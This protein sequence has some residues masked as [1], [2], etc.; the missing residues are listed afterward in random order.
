MFRQTEG[1]VG[2][3]RGAVPRLTEASLSLRL[4][5]VIILGR[6]GEFEEKKKL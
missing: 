3:T 6:Y 1:R 2:S 5:L 4:G